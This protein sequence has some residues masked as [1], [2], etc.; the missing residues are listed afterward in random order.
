[1]TEFSTTLEDFYFI[2]NYR[3]CYHTKYNTGI[4]QPFSS[5]HHLNCAKKKKKK[6]KERKQVQSMTVLL[7]MLNRSITSSVYTSSTAKG[8]VSIVTHSHHLVVIIK[9]P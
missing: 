9:L 1:V 4:S 6:K 5:S 3:L 8:D 7:K 2:Y